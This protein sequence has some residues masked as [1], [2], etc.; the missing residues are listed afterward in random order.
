MIDECPVCKEKAVLWCRCPVRHS[1]CKN[2]HEWHYCYA[3]DRIV[4]GP[5]AHTT[6]SINCNCFQESSPRRNPS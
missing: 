2:G 4:T 6:N 3:C 1:E 5:A